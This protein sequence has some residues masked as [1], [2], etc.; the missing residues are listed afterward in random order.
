MRDPQTIRKATEGVRAVYHICPNMLPD[1]VGIGETVIAAATSAGIERFVYHSVLHPQTEK[2]PHHWHK[3]RV[4]E[5][6]IESGLPFTILQ[7]TAYMQNLLVAWQAISEQGVYA[8]PYPVGS[9][10]SLVD[11]A[12]V[13]EIAAKVLTESGHLGATYELVGTDPLPQTA[14]AAV[15]AEQLDRPV[16][17]Q[18]IPLEK[19]QGDAE[20]AG[21][22]SPFALDTLLHM[23]RYYAAFGLAGN[24]RVLELL[25]GR[26]PTSL[27]AFVER[28]RD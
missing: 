1:E 9:R 8:V 10:L 27:S 20:A 12:D 11:L 28:N 24:P 25:L 21:Q 18:E 16:M 22:L 19:W 6:L 23:F 14:V 26:A 2:M 4:E 3:L 7:P 15:F 13:A 5:M 17:A